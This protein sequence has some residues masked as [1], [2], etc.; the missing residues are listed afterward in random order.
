MLMGSQVT[1]DSGHLSWAWHV[2]LL[3]VVGLTGMSPCCRLDSILFHCIHSRIQAEKAAATG[4]SSFGDAQEGKP[5][6][7]STFKA[8]P[9]GITANTPLV[10]T[11]HMT[12]FQ[13]Q[14]AGR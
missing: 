1:Q 9:Y 14:R 2:T 7:I 10:K 8:F 12:K 5:I 4:A 11:V 3:P 13:H 6:Y